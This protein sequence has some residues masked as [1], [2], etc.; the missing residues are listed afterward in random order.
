MFCPLAPSSVT[1]KH[2]SRPNQ[3]KIYFPVKNYLPWDFCLG[4]GSRSL[5]V[6]CVPVETVLVACVSD[7]RVK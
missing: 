4:G 5:S 7:N 2:F 1:L 3:E 6:V